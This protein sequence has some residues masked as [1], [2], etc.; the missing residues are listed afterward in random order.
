MNLN[1]L[2]DKYV[3]ETLFRIPIICKNVCV[4]EVIQFPSSCE[5]LYPKYVN[6]KKF[7]GRKIKPPPSVL[8]TPRKFNAIIHVI[9]CGV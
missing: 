1:C 4:F 6:V 2:W 9:I 7:M 3:I 5:L 8:K